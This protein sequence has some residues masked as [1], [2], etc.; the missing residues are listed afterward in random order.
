[1]SSSGLHDETEPPARVG[2]VAQHVRDVV[3]D[4]VDGDLVVGAPR[5]DDVSMLLS[6]HTE[7]LIG[8]L[9]E[10]YVVVQYLHSRDTIVVQ[11]LHSRDNIVV[12]YLH[13]RDNIVVQCLHSRDN[14]VVQCLHS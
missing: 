14:I 10:V 2:R 6:R 12:Q 13:S 5:D 8:G 11:Y 9:H 1:M 7:L 4:Q 3:A